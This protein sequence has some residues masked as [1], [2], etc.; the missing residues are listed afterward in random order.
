MHQMGR[1]SPS[2]STHRPGLTEA[3]PVPVLLYELHIRGL[4]EAGQIHAGICNPAGFFI[5][6]AANL[7][8][9]DSLSCGPCLCVR[10]LF[11]RELAVLVLR[12]GRGRDEASGERDI[13][14]GEVDVV[15]RRRREEGR[16]ERGWCLS[17]RSMVG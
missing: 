15:G 1:I 14:S 3:H 11:A 10:P 2:L 13:G 5:S 16:H 7:S 6:H 8:Q 9:K 4:H 12:E 17:C